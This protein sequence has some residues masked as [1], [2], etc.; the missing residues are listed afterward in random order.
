MKNIAI[1][2]HSLSHGGAERIAG[3]LSKQLSRYYNV[4]VFLTENEIN[5]EYGGTLVVLGTNEKNASEMI[6]ELAKRKFYNYLY[7]PV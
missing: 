6:T 3:Y 7:I 4:F 2:T 1:L 5:Y